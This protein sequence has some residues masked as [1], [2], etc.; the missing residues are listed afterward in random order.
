MVKVVGIEL[1]IDEF[2]LSFL[3]GFGVFFLFLYFGKYVDMLSDK[4]QCYGVWVWLVN[5]GWVNGFYGVGSCIK[6]KYICVMI[7]VVLNG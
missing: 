6:F 7:I 1:G 2:V 5:I 3:V 4:M